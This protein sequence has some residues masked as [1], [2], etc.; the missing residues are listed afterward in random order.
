VFPTAQDLADSFPALLH[1]LDEPVA[2]AAV[3]PQ[4]FLSRLA[5][6]NVKVVLGGQ[7]G[8]EIF[9]GYA[10]YLVAYLE[11][12]LQRAVYGEA[13]MVGDLTLEAIAPAL[14]Y[15]RGYEPM[16]QAQF[17]AGVF[18]EPAE[19][20]YRLLCRSQDMESIL[21]PVW[22]EPGYATLEAFREEFARPR[23]DHLIDRMLYVDIRNHL[24]SLLHLEDRTSMAVSLESRLPLLDHRLVERVFAAPVAQR[25]AAGRPKHLL[26]R[27][28]VGVVPQ[29]VLD[30]RDKMG[31][32]VPIYEWFRGELRV[33]VEDVM[34]G[35]TARQRGIYDLPALERALRSERPF[36]RTVWGLLS[37]ELWFRGFF[38]RR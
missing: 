20:Y 25:F 30:R 1:Y 34:L 24:Q 29:E 32:P 18:A 12:C 36:G 28:L 9:C 22:Q 2:G 38:D 14:T 11:A 37:L 16:I 15:L 35:P 4:Y 8:D 31:F 26:R 13:P 5:A 3:F 7:G 10:R 21:Q 6:A 19:R 23:T 27:A 33:F 17:G